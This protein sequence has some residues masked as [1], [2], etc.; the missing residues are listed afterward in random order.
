MDPKLEKDLALTAMKAAALS[1]R[2][3]LA[4]SMADLINECHQLVALQQKVITVLTE[5]LTAYETSVNPVSE[6][7]RATPS[8]PPVRDS[9]TSGRLDISGLKE[10]RSA[11]VVRDSRQVSGG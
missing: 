3:Q 8:T 7:V 9:I 5:K 2:C 10:V 1:H 11:D 4:L 6:S